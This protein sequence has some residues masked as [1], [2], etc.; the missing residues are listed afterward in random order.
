MEKN[1]R[2]DLQKSEKEFTN[3]NENSKE[4]FTTKE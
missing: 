1:Q 2:K 4:E 3:E